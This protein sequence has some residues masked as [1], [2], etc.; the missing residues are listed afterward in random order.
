MLTDVLQAS[1]LLRAVAPVAQPVVTDFVNP[2]TRP[3]RGYLTLL[4]VADVVHHDR[5][6]N[7]VWCALADTTHVVYA[8][9]PYRPAVARFEAT[10]DQRFTYRI[11]DTLVALDRAHLRMYASLP[12]AAPRLPPP[13]GYAVL[14]VEAFSLFLRMGIPPAQPLVGWVYASPSYGGVVDYAEGA[15]Q[16]EEDDDGI[17]DG[18]S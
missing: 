10:Y 4:R 12:F 11:R 1:W 16:L 7:D 14:E 9:F 3:R 13:K 17:S 15:R 6:S 8:R 5:D 2:R 18:Y